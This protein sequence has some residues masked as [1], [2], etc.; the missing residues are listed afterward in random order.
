ML[1]SQGLHM[2]PRMR[3][4][5]QRMRAHGLWVE[6]RHQ[7]PGHKPTS[8]T[9]SNSDYHR[10]DL[11]TEL[12]I[13]V[14]EQLLALAPGDEARSEAAEHT[15]DGVQVVDARGVQQPDSVYTAP[16]QAMVRC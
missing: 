16:Q 15:G 6:D 9:D 12:C 3:V 11:K 10:N 7:P 14:A 1:M 5:K 8:H 4:I 2:H 13:A